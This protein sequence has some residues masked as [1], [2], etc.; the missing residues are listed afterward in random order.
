MLELYYLFDTTDWESQ[1]EIEQ[2]KILLFF[3]LVL[4]SSVKFFVTSIFNEIKYVF[5][6]ENLE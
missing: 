4:S 6:N 5:I 2:S 3:N 1:L